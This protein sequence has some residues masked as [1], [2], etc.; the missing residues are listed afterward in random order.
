MLCLEN[1][2]AYNGQ[3][4]TIRSK[5]HHDGLQHVPGYLQHLHGTVGK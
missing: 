3:E 2:T 1:R 5:V 4:E